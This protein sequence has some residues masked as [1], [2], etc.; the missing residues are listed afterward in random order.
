MRVSDPHPLR[1]E[2]RLAHASTHADIKAIR[3]LCHAVA[4]LI[5]K[6]RLTFIEM[7]EAKPSMND[8]EFT[9]AFNDIIG[10]IA[11]QRHIMVITEEACASLS[12]NEHM[13]TEHTTS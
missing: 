2:D 6:S 5:L 10:A 3:R 7:S 11:T 12:S 1:W 4:T 13:H 9:Q 8:D